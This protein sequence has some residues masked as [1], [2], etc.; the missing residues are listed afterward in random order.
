MSIIKNHWELHDFCHS[1]GRVIPH[2]SGNS[3]DFTVFHCADRSHDDSENV[4]CSEGIGTCQA[5]MIGILTMSG[6][7]VEFDDKR[8]YLLCTQSE[9]EELKKISDKEKAERKTEEEKNPNAGSKNPARPE[10]VKI[11]RDIQDIS[12]KAYGRCTEYPVRMMA[13]RARGY[14]TPPYIWGDNS[15][16]QLICK[17]DCI[18]PACPFYDRRLLDELR[19]NHRSDY[20]DW[21]M[22]YMKN[23]R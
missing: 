16:T 7:V 9:F 23:F 21:V 8:E 20:D 6:I 11:T 17:E 12:Y 10:G 18:F 2:N 14:L 5:T 3:P 13:A 22:T 4:I 15:Y 1:H 19:H